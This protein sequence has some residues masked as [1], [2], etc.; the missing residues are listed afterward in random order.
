MSRQTLFAGC[1]FFLLILISFLAAYQR[2][3]V[4]ENP[5]KFTVVIPDVE[6]VNFG[7]TSW[8][9]TMAEADLKLTGCSSKAVIRHLAEIGLTALPK[10]RSLRT[11][12]VTVMV[13]VTNNEHPFH[14]L[15]INKRGEVHIKRN[16]KSTLTDTQLKHFAELLYADPY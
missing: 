12:C 10:N 5:M 6:I 3:Y 7:S 8:G 11:D 9:D 14:R 2:E 15:S 13:M 1:V 4:K 16:P